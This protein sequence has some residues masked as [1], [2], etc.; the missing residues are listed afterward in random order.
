M[1]SKISIYSIPLSSRWTFIYLDRGY[2]EKDGHAVVLRRG[3]VLLHIP[4]GQTCCLMLGP[5]CVV[6]HEAI[7]TCAQEKT[8]LLWVGENGVRCYS[9]GQPG[10]A[11][12]E[13]ILHQA[14]LCLDPILRLSVARKL[15]KYMFGEEPPQK[16]SIDELRGLEG[17][18]VKQFYK[19]CASRNKVTW[20][21]RDYET[22]DFSSG[23]DLNRALSTATTALYGLCEAVILAIGYCPAIGFIHSGNARS[24]VFDLADTVK[25]DLS[26]EIA[27]SVV[28]KKPANIESEVRKACRDK[29]KEINLASRLVSIL[30]DVLS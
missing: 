24:F 8:L 16:R 3:D 28:S 26:V 18:R 17:S 4:V 13:N 9:A 15:Y 12:G 2:L 7:K 6:T 1:F 10:G 30:E 27:F 22:D 11:S 25:M 5:G 19:D 23:D 21:K 20:I 29:F 14:S